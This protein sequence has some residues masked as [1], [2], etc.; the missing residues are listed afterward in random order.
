MPKINIDRDRCKGCLLCIS[1]CPQGVIKLDDKLNAQGIRPVKFSPLKRTGHSKDKAGS[2][3][4][5]ITK[6]QCTGCMRCALI[7]PDSCIEV[8]K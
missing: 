3:A 1:F 5:L 8:Y 7:C 4:E 2:S 6:G